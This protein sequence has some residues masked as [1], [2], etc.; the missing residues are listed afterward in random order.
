MNQKK[1]KIII[2][3]VLTVVVAVTGLYIYRLKT[4]NAVDLLSENKLLVNVLIAGTNVFNDNKHKFYC[5]VS[6]NPENS[7]VGITFLPPSLKVDLSGDGDFVRLDEVDIGDFG[8]LSSFIYRTMKIRVPFY[9]VLYSPDVVRIVD[10]AEG[11]NLYV[12]D[13]VKDIDGL[14]H[15]LNY[16]D[17]KKVSGYINYADDNSIFKRYD[18][19][20]DILF[21]LYYNRSEYQR[22][23]T[24]DYMSEAM[25]T[26]KT[27]LLPHEAVSIGKI[28]MNE[29]DLMCTVLPGSVT[30]EGDFLM[31]EVAYKMYESG[32]LKKL[33]LKDDTETNIKVK[34][35]NA[36]DVP[37]I[38]KKMRQLLVR[39]GVSVVE[40]G[41]YPGLVLDESVIINQKGDIESVKKISEMTGITKIYHIIDSTQLHSVLF[42]AGKDLAK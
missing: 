19:I 14:R 10:L 41:T 40:F 4:R 6:I 33:V 39:E 26:V 27:N 22:F 23:I 1:L 7:R 32:F 8:K 35:L 36:S 25:K 21:T 30:P 12:L 9:A 38:A 18:R 3:S 2:I 13:Q 28:I 31:D 20:Q 34:V 16:L 42:I 15:G 29:G 24:A 17:G 5:V 37:G 11:I